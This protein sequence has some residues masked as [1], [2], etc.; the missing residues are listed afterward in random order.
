M[1]G[2]GTLSGRAAVVTGAGSGIGRGIALALAAAGGDVLVADLMP[3]R[4]EETARMITEGG[5]RAVPFTGDISDPDSVQAMID[6]AMERFGGLGILVNNAG[7]QHVAPIEEF[8]LERW[9]RLINV[10]LTGPF[11]CTRAALPHMRRA[12]WGRIINISSIHGKVASPFKAAYIAAKHGL[13]GLT[14]TTAVETATAGI[15]ANAICPGF[16]DTPL[17]RNQ[18]PDLMRNFAVAT[19]E[20]ALEIAVFSKTPQRRLLDPAE[21]GALAVYLAG[22]AARGVTGQAINLDG[23]MVMY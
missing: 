15:T 1:S 7:L 21:V 20:E 3:D 17:V 14:R 19:A 5:G 11:L 9:N 8:P 2:T 22:E 6:T 18:I 23:G 13:I 12:G 4:A 10:M 16:V